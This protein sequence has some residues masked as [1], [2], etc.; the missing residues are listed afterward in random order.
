M[1]ARPT[2]FYAEGFLD[3]IETCPLAEFEDDEDERE[4][5]EGESEKAQ[6]EQEVGWWDVFVEG[7]DDFVKGLVGCFCGGI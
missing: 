3:C 5:E 6:A 1:R 4:K 2:E 7:F